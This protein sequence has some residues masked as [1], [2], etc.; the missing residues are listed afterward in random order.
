MDNITISPDVN[1]AVYD[2]LTELLS[3]QMGLSV[4]QF[5][6]AYKVMPSQIVMAVALNTGTSVYT[7]NP[8]K[9][10]DAPVPGTVLLDQNDW[11]AATGI[12]L[13]LGRADFAGNTYSNHGNYPKLTYPDPNYF[14][15]TGTT[16]GSE[17]KSLLNIVNGTISVSVQ[18]DAQIDPIPAQSLF[19]NPMATYTSSPVAYPQFGGSPEEQGFYSLTPNLIL[20]ASADNTFNIALANGAKGN[21]DGAISTGTTDST[22]RNFLYV[23]VS[24]W[25]IKNL[26]GTGA[27]L[28][29]NR[30]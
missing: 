4:V 2:R 13:R 7:L 23:F 28:T 8:R 1:R 20:D 10:V 21:I 14:T 15:G 30:V 17:L 5:T 16:A 11:F 29:C 27:S 6:G 22:V 18:G 26:G 9:T 25:K 3:K 12:S 24:G 19:F